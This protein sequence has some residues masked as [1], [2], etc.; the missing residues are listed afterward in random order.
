MATHKTTT[1]RAGLSF[2]LLLALLPLGCDKGADKG[3]GKSGEQKA[4]E[5][6][7]GGPCA[8]D[9]DCKSDKLICMYEKCV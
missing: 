1:I 2:G 7:A 8:W 6:A 9:E 5:V 3:G 4:A